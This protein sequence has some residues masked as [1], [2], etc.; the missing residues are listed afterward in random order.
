MFEINDAMYGLRNLAVGDEEQTRI[1]DYTGLP[2]EVSALVDAGQYE[3]AYGLMIRRTLGGIT[4]DG[5]RTL[6]TGWASTWCVEADEE[7][8]PQVLAADMLTAY[9]DLQLSVSTGTSLDA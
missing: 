3:Q 5:V 8:D 4:R 2:L 7:E 9:D 6:I 1:G